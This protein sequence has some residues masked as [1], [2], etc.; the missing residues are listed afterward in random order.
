MRAR[1]PDS[2]RP[3]GLRPVRLLLVGF[4]RQEYGAGL[5]LPSPTGKRGHATYSLGPKRAKFIYSLTQLYLR[6]RQLTPWDHKGQGVA[7]RRGALGLLAGCPVNECGGGPRQRESLPQ[8]GSAGTCLLWPPSR[9]FLSRGACWECA[10]QSLLKGGK[11]VQGRETKAS[12]IPPSLSE[13]PQPVPRRGTSKSELAHTAS[14]DAR[15]QE[16]SRR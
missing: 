3:P 15:H 6:V 1:L 7:R 14:P 8:T 12:I 13:T 5:P 11:S 16:S 2:T 10:S 9:L 4:P